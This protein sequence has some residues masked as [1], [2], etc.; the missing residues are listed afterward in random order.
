MLKNIELI[1]IAN[2]SPSKRSNNPPW[3]GNKDD[4][5]FSFDFLFKKDMKI[6]P[7]WETVEVIIIRKNKHTWSNTY[8]SGDYRFWIGRKAWSG[9]ITGYY[10]GSKN[11]KEVF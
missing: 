2:I 3:P 7:I 9:W 10:E 4:A 1:G 8:F 11:K 5:S 6:S